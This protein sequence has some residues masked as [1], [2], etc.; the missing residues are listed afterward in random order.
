[1]RDQVDK[2][3]Q[4]D[5]MG[6]EMFGDQVDMIYQLDLMGQE[7]FSDQV[8]KIY[9]VD[10]KGQEMFSSQVDRIYRVDLMAQEMLPDGKT[11][12]DKAV[13]RAA[14]LPQLQ[15]MKDKAGQQ[16]VPLDHRWTWRTRRAWRHQCP[17]DPGSEFVK[18]IGTCCERLRR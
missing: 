2:I 10:I 3:Y 8:D 4:V 16:A 12:C 5:F 9:Q 11:M 15:V 7:M 6:Q 14:L 18:D 17:Q 13:Q 1:M